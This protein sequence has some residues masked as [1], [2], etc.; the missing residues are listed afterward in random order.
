MPFWAGTMGLP[1]VPGPCSR[2]ASVRCNCPMTRR[3]STRC[4]MRGISCRARDWRRCWRWPSGRACRSCWPSMSVCRR[5]TRRPRSRPLL[6]GM[7]AGAD[8]ID[9]MDL[10]RHG[11]MDRLFTG[12]RAPSTLGTF[13]RAFRFGHVR[14]VDAVAARLL[15]RLAARTPL[16]PGAD[17][18]AYVDVDDTVRETHGY[19]KQGAGFG[20]SGVSGLNALLGVVSTPTAAPVVAAARLRKGSTNS[21]RGA[22]R[23]VSDALKTAKAAGADPTAGALVIARMDSAFYGHDVIAAVR[24]AG[25]KFSVTARMSPTVTAAIAGID[26]AAWTA[27]HYPNAFTDPDTGELVSDAEVAEVPAFTAFTSRRK[28][29]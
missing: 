14:Q 27:I 2:R 15:A 10:L 20:Y 21:A 19:A 6:A 9:D 13:L 7:V 17:R 3:R 4:S 29:E 12:V 22:A 18:V 26:E 11:A 5:R 25:A 1:R 23:L 28:N 8:S 24:R 16:L